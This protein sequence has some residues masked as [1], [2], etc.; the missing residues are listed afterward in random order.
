MPISEGLVGSSTVPGSKQFRVD[1]KDMALASGC[2]GFHPYTHLKC[3]MS[4]LGKGFQFLC[5]SFCIHKI[6]TT[7]IPI[8]YKV[9][10]RIT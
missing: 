7:G 4:N 8:S 1:L 2:L 6:R 3:I 9:F 5:C 10:V